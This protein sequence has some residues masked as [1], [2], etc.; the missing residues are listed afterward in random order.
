MPS[1]QR[2]VKATLH[3]RLENGETWEA[4]PEDLD[5]F[6][7]VNRLDAYVA[8]D[9]HLMKILHAAGVLD[10][11]DDLTKSQLNPLRY[12][13]EIAISHPALLTHPEMAENDAAVVDIERA[14]LAID[15]DA[16]QEA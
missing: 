9:D 6:G 10:E 13:V 14:L 1:Y 8:F 3:V 5:Q 7:Y 2:P 12:L 16:P 15:P 11:N 4:K